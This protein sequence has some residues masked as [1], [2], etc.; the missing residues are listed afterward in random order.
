MNKPNE[1]RNAL[2]RLRVA[3]GIC[4]RSLRALRFARQD[5]ETALR[6]TGKAERDWESLKASLEEAGDV[7]EEILGDLSGKGKHD[8]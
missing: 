7:I 5:L 2:D 8:S 4:V 1:L 3:E 6:E